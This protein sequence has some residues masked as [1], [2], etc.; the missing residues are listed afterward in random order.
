M[1]PVTLLETV[2]LHLLETQLETQLVR[3][4]EALPTPQPETLMWLQ[5]ETQPETLPETLPETQLTTV[6]K[7]QPLEMHLLLLPQTRL[8]TRPET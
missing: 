3:P 2:A 6:L 5:P 8:E 4:P 1:P 7:M